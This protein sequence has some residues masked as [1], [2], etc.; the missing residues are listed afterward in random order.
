MYRMCIGKVRYFQANEENLRLLRESLATIKID[1][2]SDIYVAL[3]NAFEILERF[4]IERQGK[5]N[6]K[7]VYAFHF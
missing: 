3:S 2:I 5:N 6:S 7:S 1:F 4:R